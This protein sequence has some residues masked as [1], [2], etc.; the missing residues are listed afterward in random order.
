VVEN[1]FG[2][3]YAEGDVNEDA[4][5]AR[6]SAETARLVDEFAHTLV[7]R[8]RQA[9]S[10]G[11]APDAPVG[12]G[13]RVSPLVVANDGFEQF[14]SDP[15]RQSRHAAQSCRSRGGRLRRLCAK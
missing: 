10:L 12:L 3:S 6:A 1:G 11:I 4:R 5:R 8:P 13:D 9:K 15:R 7:T 14:L 2:R